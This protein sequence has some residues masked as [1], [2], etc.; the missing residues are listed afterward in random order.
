MIAELIEIGTP[1][2]LKGNQYGCS[3]SNP[4]WGRYK[5]R[6]VG[7]IRNYPTNKLSC[8]VLW[9]YENDTVIN[10]YSSDTLAKINN[11]NTLCECYDVNYNRLMEVKKKEIEKFIE[12]PEEPPEVKIRGIFNLE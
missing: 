1:V 4:V 9:V 12:P 2:I 6:V 10:T 8:Q 11:L 5:E 7:F 3:R